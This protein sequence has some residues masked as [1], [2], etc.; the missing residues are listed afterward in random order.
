[1]DS[2]VV[3]LLQQLTAN[4]NTL[5]QLQSVLTL[6]NENNNNNNN[7]NNSSQETLLQSNVSGTSSPP[8]S[9]T[10]TA[11]N[12][13]KGP[14]THARPNSNNNNNREEYFRRQCEEKDSVI[15]QLKGQM[16]LMKKE[17]QLHVSETEKRINAAD[18]RYRAAE[19]E[20]AK[21]SQ[22]LEKLTE[23]VESQKKQAARTGERHALELEATKQSYEKILQQ[24]ED[25]FEDTLKKMVKVNQLKS[26]AMQFEDTVK[27]AKS[28]R[29]LPMNEPYTVVKKKE[30]V[31]K[32]DSVPLTGVKRE[33]TEEEALYEE[34]HGRPYQPRPHSEVLSST[35]TSTSVKRS[36]HIVATASRGRHKAR[37]T[38]RTPSA[39]H[40]D[41][42]HS[43]S[44]AP[45]MKSAPQ[46]GEVRPSTAFVEQ[47][48]QPQQRPPYRPVGRVAGR[49]PHAAVAPVP[50]VP[51]GTSSPAL[52]PTRS[53]SPVNPRRG[54]VA[55]RRFLFTALP[56]DEVLDLKE[57]ITAMGQDSAYIQQGETDEAPHRSTTHV[58]L[59]GA[60]RTVKA[61]SALVS[62]MWLVSPDYI[63]NSR[64]AG[65]WLDESDEGGLRVFPPP[66]KCQ[67]FLLSIPNEALKEKLAEVIHYGGGDIVEFTNSKVEEEEVVV[68]TSGA[69]LLKYAT[70]RP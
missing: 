54:P 64:R 44:P 17:Q 15:Q 38:P 52:G 29:E 57:H 34:V 60:P 68:I 47:Y 49:L 3:Q 27:T 13:H 1:M 53:P 8:V 14:T 32:P 18:Q 28:L 58:V 35:P 10:H 66:L 55:P 23:T 21:L 12:A 56:E 6:I 37:R 67:R 70:S 20:V 61:L 40:A 51:S 69:D 24:K 65:F 9:L 25:A 22:R 63:T 42:V 33:R 19:K 43:R 26:V 46:E 30:P 41:R 7:S 11:Y 5:N 36:T 45:A 50:N 31:V 16:D 2:N 48:N 62:G 4:P 59:R 39:T